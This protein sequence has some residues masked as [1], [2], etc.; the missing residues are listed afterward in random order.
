MF[1]KETKSIRGIKEID[2]EGSTPL[3]SALR[4][5]CGNEV[6]LLI[7]GGANINAKD[8]NGQTPLHM[9]VESGHTNE[10]WLLLAE[11]VDIDVKD[12]NGDTPLQLAKQY[13]EREVIRFLRRHAAKEQI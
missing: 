9:A 12:N 8:K 13:R 3:H 4:R 5:G 7:A 11:G 2:T 6:R 10:V 1:N